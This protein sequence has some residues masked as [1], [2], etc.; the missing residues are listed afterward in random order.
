MNREPSTVVAPPGS[1]AAT[2]TRRGKFS[3]ADRSGTGGPGLAAGAGDDDDDEAD[4][5]ADLV[6][7]GVVV[8]AAA[9]AAAPCPFRTPP[10]V[11]VRV[12]PVLVPVPVE[13][14][15]EPVRLAMVGRAVISSRRAAVARRDATVVQQGAGLQCSGA[16]A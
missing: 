10:G 9:A 6:A 1:P 8:A 2:P 11:P 5:D 16:A 14:A 7:V 4:P 13:S 12:A 3:S 15:G